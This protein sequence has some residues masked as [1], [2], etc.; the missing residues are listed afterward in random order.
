MLGQKLITAANRLLPVKIVASETFVDTD[1]RTKYTFNGTLDAG[2]GEIVVGLMAIHTGGGTTRG[3]V[4]NVGGNSTILHPRKSGF[5]R[6]VGAAI[7]YKFGP[8]NNPVSEATTIVETDTGS[9]V[10]AREAASTH[11]I[12]SGV[13][14]VPWGSQYRDEF[15][16]NA[17][18]ATFNFTGIADSIVLAIAAQSGVGSITWTGAT[19]LVSRTYGEA[20]MSVAYVIGDGSNVS[21]SASTTG[22]TKDYIAA[23]ATFAP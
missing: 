23:A 1:N 10:V 7:G 11:I 19:P 14:N 6:K 21:F 2:P 12:L 17:S 22:G 9:L 20:S 18:Q 3:L 16:S 5:S 4:A 8:I 15:T 13:K